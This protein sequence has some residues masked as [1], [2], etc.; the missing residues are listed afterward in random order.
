L[1]T[2]NLAGMGSA[3]RPGFEA[4][5]GPPPGLYPIT[6]AA[7]GAPGPLEQVELLPQSM[8]TSLVSPGLTL[9]LSFS[10]RRGTDLSGLSTSSREV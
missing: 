5:G 2:R 9:G 7:T 3:V 1:W 4:P 10:I 6:G 8:A